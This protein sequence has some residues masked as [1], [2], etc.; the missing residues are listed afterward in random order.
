[1]DFET[2]RCE[3]MKAEGF[4]SEGLWLLRCMTVSLIVLTVLSVWAISLLRR[5]EYTVSWMSDSLEL[6][7]SKLSHIEERLMHHRL[8]AH[9][10]LRHLM[11][12]VSTFDPDCDSAYLVRK[13][14]DWVSMFIE[15][16]VSVGVD[17]REILPLLKYV[18]GVMRLRL[19]GDRNDGCLHLVTSYVLRWRYRSFR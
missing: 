18:V 8:R 11:Q 13:V 3:S 12:E 16:R 17:R 1:M 2:G 19:Y 6:H 9:E 10:L 15:V 5:T 7:S 14:A 4:P